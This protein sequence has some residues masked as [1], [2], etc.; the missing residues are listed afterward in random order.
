[1][2]TYWTL[3][4]LS[5]SRLLFMRTRDSLTVVRLY[6]QTFGSLRMVLVGFN[7]Q[8]ICHSLTWSPRSS[9]ID[10]DG[11][12]EEWIRFYNFIIFLNGT[13][14]LIYL[15]ALIHVCQALLLNFCS[16]R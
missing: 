3:L 14:R 5:T 11:M 1:M 8:S 7:A 15:M 4:T 16:E 10:I 9:V 2:L 12:I 13:V 6:I